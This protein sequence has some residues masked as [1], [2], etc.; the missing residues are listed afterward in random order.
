MLHARSVMHTAHAV[1]IVCLCRLIS[2]LST[3]V[4]VIYSIRNQEIGIP[5]SERLMGVSE[6]E[7]VGVCKWRN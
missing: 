5:R 3:V 7:L 2:R 1:F 6:S 4:S